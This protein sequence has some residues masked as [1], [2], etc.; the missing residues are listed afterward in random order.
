MRKGDCV[1]GRFEI[2]ERIGAGGMGEVYRALDRMNG[3]NV[4]VKVLRELELD[5]T[6]QFAREVRALASF[7]HAHVVKYVTH[8]ISSTGEPYLVMEWLTGESLSQRLA[9]E[10]LNIAESVALV[11]CVAEA[12][13]AAHTRGIVHRD[14]KPSNLFLVDGRPEDV[15]VLDFGIARLAGSTRTLRRTGTALGTAGYMAPEQARGEREGVDARADVFSLGCVLFEC[16]AGRPAFQGA[17]K[18]VL[19]AKVLF[20]EPPRVSR[21]NHQVPA[22][23][24]ELVSRLLSKE[25]AERPED[26]LA[27]A[28][29]LGS[30]GRLSEDGAP[31]QLPPPAVLSNVERHMVSI[32]AA[33]IAL[34]P[35]ATSTPATSPAPNEATLALH[36][37]VR[38]AAT[39]F[40]AKVEALGDGGIVAML[41]GAGNAADRTALAAR[42]ALE[43]AAAVPGEA[44]ALVTGWGESKEVLPVGEVLDRAAR[45][46]QGGGATAQEVQ[47]IAVRID[48]VTRALLDARFEV[49]EEAGELLLCGERADGESTRPLLGKPSRFV[50]RERELRH[51]V[52]L[53]ETSFAEP[54]PIAILVT[55]PAGMGKSRLGRE[56][57]HVVRSHRG[58]LMV[59]MGRGDSIGVGSP[60]AILAA[61][62]R[63][64]LGIRTGEPLDVQRNTLAT[65]VG[66]YVGH[67]ERRR[68]TE[69]LGEL[70]GVP[71]PDEESPQLR[72][73]RRHLHSMAA[74]I[75]TACLELLRGLAAARPV[76]LVLE[77]L[78]WGD[79]PSVRLLDTALRELADSPL[80]VLA[81]ARLEVHERF[82]G[83]WAARH[84]QEMRLS[85]LSH[86]AAAKLVQN[87]LGDAIDAD[88]VGTLV[89]HAG[90]NAFYLEELIRAAAA[91][92]SDGNALPETV[93]GMVETRLASLD[94]EARRLLRAGSVWGHRFCTSGALALLGE[95]THEVW[96]EVLADL[97]EHEILTQVPHAEQRFAGEDEH[98]FRHALIREAAYAM[99]TERD[100]VAG[101]RR[102]G[103]WLL[104][105]GAHDPLVLAEHFAHG[106]DGMRAAVFY[107]R[108]ADQAL[109]AHDLASAGAHA[110]KGLS[111]EPEA[112][113]Q[114][115]LHMVLA[116]VRAFVGD[117][118][119]GYRNAAR[120]LELAAPGTRIYG[121]ACST[122]AMI[123]G[124]AGQYESVAVLARELLA[125]KLT[126]VDERHLVNAFSGLCFAL[127][128]GGMV[129]KA[130]ECRRRLE[131]IAVSSHGYDPALTARLEGAHAQWKRLVERDPWAALG[132]GRT[133]ARCHEL[134]GEVAYGHMQIHLASNDLV[135][136]GAIAEARETLERLHASGVTLGNT[137]LWAAYCEALLHVQAGH[138]DEAIRVAT[139]IQTAAM[140]RASVALHEKA[141]DLLIQALIQHGDIREAER[142]VLALGELHDR[143]L[144]E[145]ADFIAALARIRLLQGRSEEAVRLSGEAL[146]VDRTAT[147]GYYS[148]RAACRL[149]HAEALHAS[150]DL[151]L[152]RQAIREAREDLLARADHIED[153]AYRHSFLAGV[154]VHVRILTLAGDWLG[155]REGL[156]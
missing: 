29:A 123:A 39:R 2:Q 108:A 11:R 147:I 141:R 135:Q 140:D 89:Q 79:A 133:A 21:L 43:I 93:L 99:L 109:L 76:L 136:L 41:V 50:G 113:T 130:K 111:F 84:S 45:L 58:D 143:P 8:G 128:A 9:G 107:Q 156:P 59:G 65:A 116:E 55:A 137:D 18:N 101:H 151:A 142:V 17:H 22:A 69:F 124:S 139:R 25:P 63:S 5:S 120:A 78:H 61:V 134:A 121:R 27:V 119:G 14:I 145:R 132:H 6:E 129:G 98:A 30:L 95:E 49:M 34:G 85:A 127:V 103:E 87:A 57:V 138:P 15:K 20:E 90:G 96:Q 26:G 68:V 19:L 126:A 48:D 33:N 75:E 35:A 47:P 60:F 70:L 148:T 46:L 54:R 4:A 155:E 12:L 117:Y 102:A 7:S 105:A 112:E 24:D 64:A 146:H 71:F 94:S 28:M 23:L 1:D 88:R 122:A 144:H 110:D 52:D 51:L 91:G 97:V 131:Q 106:G 40:G 150:G 81:L 67:D 118:P 74:Q 86:H 82:P 13:G 149:I 153:P 36:L 10:G 154:S 73:A 100:R 104:Q 152:A 114:A 83:L 62:L 31:R 37:A 3:E 16:L 32:V 38:R 80:A 77:D 66:P 72:A 53:T 115:A 56:F 42:C 92:H 44:I 125:A